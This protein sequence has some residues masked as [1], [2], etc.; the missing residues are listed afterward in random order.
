MVSLAVPKH[1]D[2]ASFFIAS[3]HRF[4]ALYQKIKDWRA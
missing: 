4:K 1:A 2:F 3:S